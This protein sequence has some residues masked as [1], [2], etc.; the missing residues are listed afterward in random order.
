[1]KL[2]GSL[3]HGR[4]CIS[5]LAAFTGTERATAAASAPDSD[6][7]GDHIAINFPSSA[8]T[9]SVVALGL[10]AIRYCLPRP[11]WHGERCRSNQER[12]GYYSRFYPDRVLALLSPDFGF[13][14]RQGRKQGRHSA[15]AR[16]PFSRLI[17]NYTGYRRILLASVAGSLISCTS[18]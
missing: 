12:V 10:A 2:L 1:M 5:T 16:T 3:E 11:Q 8:T 18:A 14:I 7:R 17:L 13:G 9:L 6:P 4:D 15:P